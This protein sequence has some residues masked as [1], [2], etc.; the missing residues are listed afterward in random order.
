VGD[1]GNSK[2]IGKYCTTSC[3]SGLFCATLGGGPNFC[4]N[5]CTL[6]D[7]GG[8]PTAC[9]AGASCQ[10]QGQCGCVPDACL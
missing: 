6:P 3:P 2:G 1:P 4:T 10:C 7:A 5:L 9:G 8:S